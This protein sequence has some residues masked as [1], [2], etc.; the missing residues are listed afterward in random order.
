MK[1][2]TVFAC[3]ALTVGGFAMSAAE[4][5]YASERGPTYQRC[6]SRFF[7]DPAGVQGW[8]E[9]EAFDCDGSPLSREEWPD[10]LMT[11]PAADEDECIDLLEACNDLHDSICLP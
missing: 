10:S 7:M 4:Y 2:T 5:A 6:F 1:P 8:C 3:L 11:V 9:I